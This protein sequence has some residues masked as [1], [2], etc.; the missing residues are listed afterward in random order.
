M[1]YVTAEELVKKIGSVYKLVLLASKRVAEL[2]AGAPKLVECNAK[3]RPGSIALEEI[4]QG[5]LKYKYRI[6]KE[7]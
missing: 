5:K 2:N 1:L 4:R 7:K 6:K 3:M